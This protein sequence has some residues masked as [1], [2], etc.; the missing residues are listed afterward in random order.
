MQSRLTS[1]L[2]SF[3]RSI[4]SSITAV[5]I[6]YWFT[7]EFYKE[8]CSPGVSLGLWAIMFINSMVWGYA[9]RRAYEKHHLTLDAR[10][11]ARRIWNGLRT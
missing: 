2:E 11:V 6:H 7:C 4:F 1:V 10:N 9:I 8:G 5:A 3:N